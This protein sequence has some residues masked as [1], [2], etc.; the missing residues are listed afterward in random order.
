MRSE[1]G[2][3]GGGQFLGS[4]L[5]EAH[6]YMYIITY[7]HNLLAYFAHRD[8]NAYFCFLV[9]GLS[10]CSDYFQNFPYERKSLSSDVLPIRMGE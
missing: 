7:T 8:P 5:C 1:E 4:L 6:D 2:G 3:R 10:T 9:L